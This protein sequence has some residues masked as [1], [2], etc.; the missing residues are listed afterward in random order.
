MCLFFPICFYI[1]FP[2][3][4]SHDAQ[5]PFVRIPSYVYNFTKHLISV[6]RLSLSLYIYFRAFLTLSLSFCFPVS[7]SLS[8]PISYFPASLSHDALLHFVNIQSHRLASL[9]RP[10][11]A[12]TPRH[13]PKSRHGL[14]LMPPRR[15]RRNFAADL[16]G[17]RYKSRAM[18]IPNAIKVSSLN[19]V[20]GCCGETLWRR[21]GGHVVPNSVFSFLSPPALFPLFVVRRGGG[22]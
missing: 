8:L 1:C 12:Q 10:P 22:M 19:L 21:R 2:A 9:R 17:R 15:R 18:V 5:F 16:P 7:L 14:S 4:L 6:T 20:R 11:A 3:S 13:E